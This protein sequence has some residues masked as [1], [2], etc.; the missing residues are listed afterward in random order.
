M[1]SGVR[2]CDAGVVL[3]DVAGGIDCDCGHLFDRLTGVFLLTAAAFAQNKVYE[4]R[5]YTC[6]E[7]KLPDLLKR[8][9]DH[10]IEIFN[11][12]GMESIGYWV[13]VDAEKSKTTLV[14]IISHASLEQAKKTWAACAC[15]ARSPS[16]PS[17]PSGPA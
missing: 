13:P 4:L 2:D 8:F 11:R 6:P 15:S 17:S 3:V 12:H 1:G 16:A 5:T 7:G 14:Y 9:R 10:T